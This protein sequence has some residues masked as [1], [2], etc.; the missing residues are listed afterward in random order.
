MN[1]GDMVTGGPGKQ[2]SLFECEGCGQSTRKVWVVHRLDM[3]VCEGCFR[4]RY[5]CVDDD[6]LAD[7]LGDDPS[8]GD[9]LAE[10]YGRPA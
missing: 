5:C 3:W 2:R 8:H 7:V 10:G 6:A 4:G 1:D 9:R